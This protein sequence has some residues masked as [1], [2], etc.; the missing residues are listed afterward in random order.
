[1]TIR[2]IVNSSEAWPFKPDRL[3]YGLHL[4]SCIVPVSPSSLSHPLQKSFLPRAA[5]THTITLLDRSACSRGRHACVHTHVHPL[6][7]HIVQHR[8]RANLPTGCRAFKARASRPDCHFD[9]ERA[10]AV[11][12]ESNERTARVGKKYAPDT[13]RVAR[14]TCT[15]V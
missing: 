6:L 7:S 4:Q 10:A 8:Y 1:M 9:L 12:S 2:G 3:F 14:S 11:L 15:R 13:F 5:R